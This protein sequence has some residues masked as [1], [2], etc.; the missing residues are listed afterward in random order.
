MTPCSNVERILK[1]PQKPA[2]WFIGGSVVHGVTEL[3][4]KEFYETGELWS[5]LR[6]DFECK[7]MMDELTA[8]AEVEEPD[9]SRWGCGGKGK[10]DG[11]WWFAQAP[12]MVL[13]WQEWRTS[14]NNLE[15][16]F[17]PNGEPAIEVEL[18]TT[19]G[20]QPV[21]MGI[22]RIMQS[23]TTGDLIVV[24]I[25]AGSRE[26]AMGYQLPLYGE[27]VRRAFGVDVAYGA[28]W[29]ARKGTLTLPKDLRQMMA[30]LDDR[31][32]KARKM[33]DNEIFLA[34]PSSFC[35]SCSVREYCEAVGGSTG[36][37]FGRVS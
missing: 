37:L 15:I 4:D 3:M 1:A 24:D 28:Y 32:S 30:Q 29:M 36:P 26:P 11:N 33:I 25:K 7:T 21:K 12:K 17:L 10:E 35:G 19:F 6:I 16:W 31:F 20:D 5:Q 9:R 13:A 2:W 22:D 27:A 8:L 14:A 34:V 23:T 18:M